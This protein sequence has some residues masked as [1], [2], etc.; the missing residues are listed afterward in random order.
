MLIGLDGGLGDDEAERARTCGASVGS[1][2]GYDA[3]QGKASIALQVAVTDAEVASNEAGAE[4][5][6]VAQ[7]PTKHGWEGH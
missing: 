4:I 2:G 1:A 3:Q 7:A 5:D 6:A